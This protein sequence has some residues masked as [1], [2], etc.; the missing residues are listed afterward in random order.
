M[1]RICVYEGSALR[2]LHFLSRQE[3]SGASD[4]QL[5]CGSRSIET[6]RE[7]TQRMRTKFGM[8]D[9]PPFV[10]MDAT[11]KRDLQRLLPDFDLVINTAGTVYDRVQGASPLLSASMS[12]RVCVYKGPFQSQERPL[13]LEAC[14]ERGLK[15]LDGA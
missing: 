6:Y 10:A 12:V 8:E 2:A 14:V 7:A 5:F 13:L 4:V 11:N 3:Q 15:Y 1:H 9:Y